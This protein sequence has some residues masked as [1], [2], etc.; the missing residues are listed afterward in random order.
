[1]PYRK[2]GPA[3]DAPFEVMLVTSRGTGRWVI[4]K[5]NVSRNLSDHAAAEREALEEAGVLGAICPVPIGEY[6]YRKLLGSGAS[7]QTDVAVFPLAVTQALEDWKEADQR[8]RQWFNLPEAAEL[9]DEEGLKAILQTFGPCTVTELS[10]NGAASGGVAVLKEGFKMFQWFQ[11]LLPRQHDFFE[12]FETHATLLAAGSDAL[13]RLLQGAKTADHAREIAEREE[14]ADQITR[15]VLQ[16][17]RRTFLTPFD[18]GAITS[19]ITAMDDALDQMKKTASAITLYD[20]Q[21]FE[22][23]MRDMAAIIVDASRLLGEALPLLRS[24]HANAGRLH[25]LTERLV[26]MEDQ[27]DEIHDR[28]LKRLY[29]EIGATEPVRFLIEREI[30]SHLEKV[31]DR[32]EDVA[33]E[34]DGLVID[35]A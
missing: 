33:N 27:A 14:E 30:Y 17:V 7:L 34:I 24:I 35:H 10:R 32:F 29:Q 9:V 22:P 12:K 23:E 11:G 16:T 21:A 25:E 15:D 28:G 26:R 31:V 4:P 5:G 3:P 19:L 8:T 1:M 18:R 2:T 6:R 20:V 13:A